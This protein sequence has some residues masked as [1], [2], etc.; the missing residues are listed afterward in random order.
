[1]QDLIGP[2]AIGGV[3]VLGVA[4]MFWHFSRSKHILRD[5][6]RRNGF[7]IVS[8]ERRF[9]FR[10]PFWWRTGKGHEVFRVTV[11]DGEGQVRSAY[12]RVGGWWGGMLSD[13]AS[14]EWD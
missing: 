12:V 8:A 7:E 14:V 4:L 11:R 10:G 5:W 6:A 9:F 3:I 13:Q 2:L 1:M